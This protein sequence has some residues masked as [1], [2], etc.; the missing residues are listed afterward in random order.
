[1]LL[2]AGHR[3]AARD[4]GVPGTMVDM[5]DAAVKEEATAISML[6]TGST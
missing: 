4:V 5:V 2:I 1:M 6:L 3:V